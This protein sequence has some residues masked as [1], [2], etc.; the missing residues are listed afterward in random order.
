ML[1]KATEK[2]LKLIQQIE[3]M[4]GVKFKGN[5]ISEARN[6]ISKHMKAYREAA[7]LCFDMVYCEGI[8]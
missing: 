1:K 7:E 6:F 2:Q 3:L 8:Y 5:S 4:L